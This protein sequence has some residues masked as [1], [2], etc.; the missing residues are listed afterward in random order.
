MHVHIFT[1]MCLN[2]III[3]SKRMKIESQF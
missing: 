2:F 1:H 3:E